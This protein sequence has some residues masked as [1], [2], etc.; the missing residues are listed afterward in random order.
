MN[1]IALLSA[2]GQVRARRSLTFSHR[3]FGVEIKRYPRSIRFMLF[4]HVRCLPERLY[5]GFD[6]IL[7]GTRDAAGKTPES[8]YRVNLT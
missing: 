4:R 5:R 8:V 1:S 7:R 2:G 6:V 3:C